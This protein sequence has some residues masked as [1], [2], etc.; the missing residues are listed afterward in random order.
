M[1]LEQRLEHIKIARWDR[2]GGVRTVR[3]AIAKTIWQLRIE[4]TAT[5]R[6]I[7]IEAGVAVKPPVGRRTAIDRARIAP[8]WARS[9]V[10]TIAALDASV[11]CAAAETVEVFA[12]RMTR[13]GAV[14]LRSP[15][16]IAIAKTLAADAVNAPG[17]RRRV[18]RS[19]IRDRRDG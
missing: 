1:I 12:Q 13:P 19:S 16:G 17:V 14:A 8:A 15:F 11:G 6:A 9:A 3:K 5:P 2:H 10:T 18:D 7:R 4:E